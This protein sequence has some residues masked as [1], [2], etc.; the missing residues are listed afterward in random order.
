[1]DQYGIV[2]FFNPEKGWGIIIP[3]DGSSDVFFH[4]AHLDMEGFRTVPNGARVCYRAEMTPK[5][6]RAVRVTP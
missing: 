2:K 4:H 3:D 5:G 1:M 6:A